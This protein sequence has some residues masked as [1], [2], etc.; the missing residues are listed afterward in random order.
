MSN[1]CIYF[2]YMKTVLTVKTDVDVKR[3]A[4]KL[5]KEM[6]VPLSTIVN[7]QLKQF[8]RDRRLEMSA[9]LIPRPRLIRAIRQARKDILEGKNMSPVFSTAD[10]MDAYLGIL[11]S[12]GVRVNVR[13]AST[14]RK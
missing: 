2:G 4:Q 12:R 14:V 3:D 11:P 1:H 6:G 13:S 5:A 7:A 8:V 10:E 9:P